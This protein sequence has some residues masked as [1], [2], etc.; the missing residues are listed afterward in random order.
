MKRIFALV[1]ALMMALAIGAYAEGGLD[2]GGVTNAT[3]YPITNEPITLDVVG[4]TRRRG[5]SRRRT[6]RLTGS[7]R[8][9]TFA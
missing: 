6:M 5:F 7:R 9:P 8:K 2:K 4:R 1:L 3:G